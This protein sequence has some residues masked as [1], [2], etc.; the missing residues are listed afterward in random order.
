MKQYTLDDFSKNYQ[1]YHS[2][3]QIDNFISTKENFNLYA[4]YKQALRELMKRVSIYREA[5]CNDKLL[6]IS[7]RELKEQ[8]KNTESFKQERLKVELVRKELK[9]D[10]SKKNLAEIMRELEKFWKHSTIFKNQLE[11]LHGELTEDKQIYLEEE[12][13]KDKYK[14][15]LAMDMSMYKEPRDALK[16]YQSFSTDTQRSLHTECPPDKA[17]EFYQ[18]IKFIDIQK[19]DMDSIKLDTGNIDLLLD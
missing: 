11:E 6:D 1:I 17:L 15:Q 9:V 7:I 8:I 13:W 2:D 19:A 4:C 12:Y 14:V 16:L 5:L 10:E 3:F 18:N